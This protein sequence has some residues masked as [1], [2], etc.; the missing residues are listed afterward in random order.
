[1]RRQYSSD[2]PEAVWEGEADMVSFLKQLAVFRD[3]VRIKHTY[4]D[5]VC[6]MLYALCCMLYAVCV[7]NPL[8]YMMYVY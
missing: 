4:L 7:L 2:D 8:T 6:F 1:V 3:L 5:A